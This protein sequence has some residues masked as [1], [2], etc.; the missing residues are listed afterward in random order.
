[1]REVNRTALVPYSAQQMFT[2]VEDVASYPQFVP[3]VK[4]AQVLERNGQVVVA[5]LEMARIG[6]HERFTTRNTLTPF[7]SIDMHLVDG[8]FRMLEGAWNFSPI[9]LDG[10]SRGSRISLRMRFEFK[11]SVIELMLS[12]VFEASCNSLIDAFTR[13]ARELHTKAAANALPAG[14][15]QR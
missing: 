2:L 6:L 5:T 4:S 9:E 13:R 12:K 3:W 10:E 15:Q 11:S 14:Q 7:T 8:P 1:M